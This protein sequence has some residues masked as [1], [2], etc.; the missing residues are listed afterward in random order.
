M[1]QLYLDDIE[2]EFLFENYDEDIINKLD[3]VNCNKIYNYLIDNGIYYAKDLF[4]SN[5]DLFLL[6]F[7]DFKIKFGKLKEKLG[8]DYIELIAE[9]GDLL[10]NMY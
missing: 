7:E 3:N 6:D 4:I 8:N 9:N 2:K 1:K 10:D 5:V